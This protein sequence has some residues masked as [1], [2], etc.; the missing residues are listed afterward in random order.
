MPKIL[1]LDN[2]S[3]EGV[4]AFEKTSG[5]GVDV[6]PPQK[7]EELAAIIGD[8]DGLVVRSG[9]KVT[10]ESIAK[11]G[12]LKVIGRAGVGT[13]NIDKEAATNAGIVVMNTPGGNTISTCE[14]TF[15]LLFALCRNV[16]KA[17]E[18]MAAGRWDRKQFMG[19][20]VRG[21]T[22]GIVGAGRIGGE[23]AK[24]AQAF[25]MK[26]IVFDPILTQMKA[27]AMGVEL[28]GIDELIERADFIT[29]HAPKTD[30]TNNLI[31]AEQFKKMKPTC[32]IV[33]CARGGIVNEQDLADALRNEEI[34]GAALDVYTSEPFDENPFIGLDNIVM[35]PHLAASTGEAQLSV[36]VDI[37]EQMIEFLNTGAIINAVNFP[38][39]DGEARDA[40]QPYLFLAE[41]LGRFQSMYMEGRPSSIQIEY[42]GD[43]GVTDTYAITAALLSG[44]LA[45]KVEMVNM[46]SAPALL[47]EHGISSTETHSPEDP[48]HAFQFKVS[49][50]TDKET[51]VV[52]G[53]LYGEDDP[54]ICSINNTRMDAEPQGWVVVFS[55]DDKPLVLGHVTTIIGSAGVNIANMTL[56]RQ[57]EGGS[58]TTLINL[59]GPLDEDTLTKL[60]KTPHVNQVRMLDL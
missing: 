47:K 56:G 32:R 58:A 16:P 11:A 29:I 41:K 13:D 26:V 55:N 4:D 31:G 34:A 12:K 6:K 52:A 44:F 53:T 46:I 28:V 15:A 25:E 9:T 45:P 30:Q 48:D 36:A 22:L 40:M 33:N 21:K 18:S 50:Q 38:S 1:V 49:V 37:A 14:H 42:S 57:T 17:H 7:P 19:A 23:V 54:R 27:D 10:A 39:L 20:E 24:R 3:R 35:T 2:L 60:R 51:N 43:F 59:D 8:Y 5:F